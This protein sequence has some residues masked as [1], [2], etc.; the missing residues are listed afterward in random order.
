MP[1]WVRLW[2]KKRGSR[3]S[4]WWV[5]GSVS[6]AAFFGVLFLLGIASLTIVVSWQVFWPDSTLWRPG[7]GFWLMVI[8]SISFM[9][10]GLT[11]F[12]LRISQTLASPE[13]RSAM[14]SEVKKAHQRRAEDAPSAITNLP[15]LQ[16]MTDSPGVKLAY[17]LASQRGESTQLIIS[18]L[19]ATAWNSVLA[20]LLVVTVQQYL[21]GGRVWF[22]GILLAG[23]LGVGIWATRWFFRLFRE[24]I[25]VGP[26]AIEIDHLPLL[27]GKQYQLY[28]CQYGRVE[29]NRLD[30]ALV[31]FEET[32]YEQGT[33][34][35][36]ESVETMRIPATITPSNTC[37]AVGPRV[38]KVTGSD[39]RDDS[40][41]DR[42]KVTGL[43]LQA[44]GDADGGAGDDQDR[45]D[46]DCG[47]QF[48]SEQVADCD[49][50]SA[51][52][53]TRDRKTK[54]NSLGGIRLK[55][56]PEV[57]L[58]L[59]CRLQ[60]PEDMM[61]SFHSEHNA[62]VWKIL[63]E[64]ECAKWPTFCRSFPVAVYPLDAV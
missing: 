50:V 24:R 29:F 61:H 19:F 44:D 34:V 16:P 14:A 53:S 3:M 31:S 8:A 58:E 28:L 64:G 52:N 33:D 63:V 26:T 62:F 25:S 39:A 4:G 55:A 45:D 37:V 41:S 57:P 47:D 15:D 11:A 12:V 40:R 49:E 59:D 6:E 38:E 43:K 13:M 1:K 42:F 60:L 32:T 7:F 9:V 30:V 54:K 36:T 23:F 18:A 20:I 51:S 35:R 2:G 56:D 46:Q 17:R 27:P 22:L 10:I 5:V 21:S 48:H